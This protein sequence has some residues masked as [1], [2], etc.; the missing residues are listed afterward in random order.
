MLSRLL[1]EAGA[2]I[3]AGSCSKRKHQPLAARPRAPIT[4]C[5]PPL[6]RLTRSPIQPIQDGG[7][8]LYVH[9]DQLQGKR[10]ITEGYGQVERREQGLHSP[11]AL[12]ATSRPRTY[13][14]QCFLISARGNLAY[15]KSNPAPALWNLSHVH[16]HMHPSRC[17]PFWRKPFCDCSST[18]CVLL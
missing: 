5:S 18:T 1:Q 10:I 14:S 6:E 17:F 9:T 3:Y 13:F 16:L 2:A 15:L 11:L 12:P 8:L 7:L 4:E